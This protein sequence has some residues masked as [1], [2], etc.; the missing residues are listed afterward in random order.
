MSS[1]MVKSA[2]SRP[3]MLAGDAFSWRGRMRTASNGTPV[4]LGW[5][6]L[7]MPQK[8]EAVG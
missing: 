6:P 4:G 5:P 1:F 2:R 8:A 3:F 7:V